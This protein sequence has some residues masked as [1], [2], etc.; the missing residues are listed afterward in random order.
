[1]AASDSTARSAST[2]TI[3]GWSASSFP[4]VDR[5][6]GVPGGLGHP[7]AHDR[8]R[9]QDA[10]EPGVV[11]H[12]DDGAAPPVP[13]RRPTGPT[14]R[15]SSI[16]LEAFDRSPSL[17]FSRWMRMG[18]RVPSGC[19]RGT[20]KQLRP[21]GAWANMRKRVRHGR[22]A[23]PLVAGEEVGAV[24]AADR[25]GPGGVGPHVGPALLLGEGHAAG[26]PGLGRSG[27][28]GRVVGGRA[29]HRLPHPGHLGLM[30]ERRHHR[31]GHRH[32]ADVPGIH[33]VP[34]DHLGRPGH[35]G[36]GSGVG[37]GSRV[38]SVAP[39]P[40]SSAGG[41]RGGTRRRR[42]GSRSGRSCAAPAGC[43]LARRPSSWADADPASRAEDLELRTGP[44]RA[45]RGRPPRRGPGRR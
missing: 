15:S 16:S 2:L 12:L 40:S 34:G 29:D 44:G 1:M 6:R 11:D 8:G 38:Q 39:P 36:T 43:S 35:V 27:S 42:S 22:R 28:V 5:W 14:R 13:R 26:D 10:V 19:Q 33:L 7:L 31:V 18:L 41:R 37:P 30:A 9:A 20:R 24:R 3:R 32:R 25:L 23:E 4:K 45:L 17:S 21:P